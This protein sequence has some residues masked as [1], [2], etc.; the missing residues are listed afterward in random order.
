MRITAKVLAEV[1]RGL[2]K[3]DHL[4]L[5]KQAIRANLDARRKHDKRRERATRGKPYDLRVIC[6][7]ELL[8]TPQEKLYLESVIED[9]VRKALKNRSAWPRPNRNAFCASMMSDFGSRN[10]FQPS[11]LSCYFTAW[12]GRVKKSGMMGE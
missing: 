5:L 4:D 9:P 1:E 2:Q 11:S 8:S 12:A 7:A 3:E 6:A 10:S